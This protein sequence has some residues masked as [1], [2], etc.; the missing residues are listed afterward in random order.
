MDKIRYIN[1]CITKF[2]EEFG[3]PAYM[4]FNYLKDHKALDFLDE[5]YAAEHLLSLEDAMD[6]MLT[7]SRRNGGTI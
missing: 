2:G 6:D 1:L 3:M 7:I 5:C 4:S